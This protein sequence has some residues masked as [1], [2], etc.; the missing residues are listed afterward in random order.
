[1]TVNEAIHRLVQNA[2]SDM[3]YME[4]QAKATSNPETMAALNEDYGRLEEAIAV[5]KTAGLDNV[6]RSPM[7]DSFIE[8]VR[9]NL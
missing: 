2:L 5:I 3:E 1:M 8:H 6:S 7:A 9:E 4:F